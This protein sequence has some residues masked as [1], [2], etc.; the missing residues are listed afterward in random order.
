[1]YRI[2]QTI[3]AAAAFLVLLSS[4]T[5]HAQSVREGDALVQPIESSGSFEAIFVNDPAIKR[6]IFETRVKGS[7]SQSLSVEANG[8]VGLTGKIE[9]RSGSKKGKLGAPYFA[10]FPLRRGKFTDTLKDTTTGA[11]TP[12]SLRVAASNP[13]G[14]AE[15]ERIKNQTGLTE[16]VIKILLN[17]MTPDEIIAKYQKAPDAPGEIPGQTPGSTPGSQ[18]QPGRISGASVLRKNAC[19]KGVDTHVV[20]FIVDLKGIDQAHYAAGFTV[21]GKV[22][23]GK[24]E[25]VAASIKPVS[26]GKFAPRPLL[27]VESMG[28]S[29]Y[30]SG[31]TLTLIP[32]K[33]NKPGKAKAMKIQDYVTY[34]GYRL[35]RVVADGI[36]KGGNATFEVSNGS[37]IGSVCVKLVRARQ[38]ING[39]PG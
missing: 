33:G 6:V 13:A 17:W 16:S 32:W 37:E 12:S 3:F 22:Y 20:R 38:R 2:R 10:Q 7:V 19:A 28:Y 30:G 5:G 9:I 39:Y 27:L 34:H 4:A 1:M 36:L 35:A 14:P 18:P 24:G 11:S 31:E 23:V 29:F 21:T 8:P 25:A 26:D 15:M